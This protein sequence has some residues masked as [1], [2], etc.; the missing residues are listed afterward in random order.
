MRGRR[1]KQDS[2]EL[3]ILTVLIDWQE[4]KEKREKRTENQFTELLIL[5]NSRRSTR[6]E[7]LELKKRNGNDEDRRE[8]RWITVQYSYDT[9]GCQM[10]CNKRA[11]MNGRK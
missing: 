2:P 9:A 10:Q 1:R 6:G 7:N 8:H 4:S 3:G 5:Q 11:Q